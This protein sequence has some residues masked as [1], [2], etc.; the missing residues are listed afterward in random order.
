MPNRQD[1]PYT[2]CLICRS[3]DHYDH[4]CPETNLQEVGPAEQVNAAQDYSWSHPNFSWKNPN[5]YLNPP[6]GPQNFLS[7]QPIATNQSQPIGLRQTQSFRPN[8][9]FSGGFRSSYQ[10]STQPPP[11]IQTTSGPILNQ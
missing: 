8:Q 11:F 2:R 6:I 10:A 1:T 4:Q 7:S 3:N 9:N 5:N